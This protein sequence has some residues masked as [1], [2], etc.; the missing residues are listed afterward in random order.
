[1]AYNSLGW[2]RNE[3]VRIPVSFSEVSKFPFSLVNKLNVRVTISTRLTTRILLF[4]NPPGI[5]SAVMESPQNETVEIGPGDLKMSFSSA[6]G[7]LEWMYNM[8]ARVSCL[9]F[10]KH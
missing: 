3:I 5:S 6:S 4:K 2:N 1:M 10:L 8:K 7:T 9:T